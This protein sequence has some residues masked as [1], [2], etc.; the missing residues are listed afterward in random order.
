MNATEV[1]EQVQHLL[2][3]ATEPGSPNTITTDEV[4]EW[5]QELVADYADEY[6]G[7]PDELAKKIMWNLWGADADMSWHALFL[8]VV[9]FADRVGFI[10]GRGPAADVRY[11]GESDFPKDISQLLDDIPTRFPNTT[12]PLYLPRKDVEAWLSA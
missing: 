7:R 6:A 10:C 5:L 9:F 1:A 12:S 2:V 4:R 11:Y 8:A 3:R